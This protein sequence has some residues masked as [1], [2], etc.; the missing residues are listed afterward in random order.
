[1]RLWIAVLTAGCSTLALAST[2]QAQSLARHVTIEAQVTALYDDNVARSNDAVASARG[3]NRGDTIISPSLV[4]DIYLPVSRQAVFLAGSV[5]YDDHQKNDILDAG[6]ARLDGGINLNVGLCQGAAT[7]GYGRAQ[8]NLQDLDVGVTRNIETDVSEALNLT[9]GRSVGLAPT[10]GISHASADNT[11]TFLVPSDSRS[12]G[13]TY[14]ISYRRPSLGVLTLFGRHDDTEYRHRQILVGSTLITDGYEQDSG[15]IR[16]DR[17]LGARIGGQIEIGYTDV[18][19]DVPTLSDFKGL[20]YNAGIDFRVSSLL[21]T[22][23]RLRHEVSATIREGAAYSIDQTVE[24][25]ATYKA[26]SRLQFS[27]GVSQ[28]VSRYKGAA[29]GLAN[30]TKEDLSA[31]FVSGRWDL[32]R[33]VA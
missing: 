32:G 25:G 16:Y 21:Q 10:F 24:L 2:A 17:H 1:M 23:L 29:L 11:N 31:I 13:Y 8:S 6:R 33:R 9:C 5:G 22:T 3:I 14:G 18:K 15:G 26:G 27:G 20:T 12:T 4:A 28:G 19:P 30:L 7:A